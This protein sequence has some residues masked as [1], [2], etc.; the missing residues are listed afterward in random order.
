MHEGRGL[1][2]I[3]D[4]STRNVRVAVV[5]DTTGRTRAGSSRGTLPPKRR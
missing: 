5:P 2:K 1:G 4:R 3:K